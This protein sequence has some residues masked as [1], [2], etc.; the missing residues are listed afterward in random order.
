LTSHGLITN[1]PN[2]YSNNVTGTTI[3]SSLRLVYVF[4]WIYWFSFFLLGHSITRAPP[5]LFVPLKELLNI[6]L[7][8]LS[9]YG[10][11][12]SGM[13]GFCWLCGSVSSVDS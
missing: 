5:L 6:E 4:N 10:Q 7:N 3:P 8:F 1:V 13:I 11:V 12:R 9:V 2:E